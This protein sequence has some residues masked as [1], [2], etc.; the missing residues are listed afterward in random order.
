M[1]LK[2]SAP[3]N[4]SQRPNVTERPLFAERL[5]RAHAAADSLVCIGLD[6]DLARLPDDLRGDPEPLLAF[7][8]RIVDATADLCAAY[9]PQI[10]F[11]SALGKEAELAASI[12]YIRERA[13]AAL[14]ILDAKRG[15]IGNTAEAYAR[16]AF[17]RYDADAVT[18]NPYRISWSR[19]CRC[20]GASRSARHPAGTG[21][22]I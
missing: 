17:D 5:K 1:A 21:T 7:N 16:E 6:P 8:R 11:Y 3:P 13:P 20:T 22:G 2:F 15:D 14:V 18:V 9:K 12:R 10:A 19:A 4:F